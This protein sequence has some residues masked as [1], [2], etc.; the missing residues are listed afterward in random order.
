MGEAG[1][2]LTGHRRPRD[3]A[4]LRLGILRKGEAGGRS[5]SYEIV[6]R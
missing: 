3:I 2:L 6:K 4:D 1:Q 5:T